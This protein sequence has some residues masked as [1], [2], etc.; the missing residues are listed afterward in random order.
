MYGQCFYRYFWYKLLQ[1]NYE[2]HKYMICRALKYSCTIPILNE[3]PLAK[4]FHGNIFN[5]ATLCK[6][7]QRAVTKIICRLVI[8][9]YCNTSSQC[10]T[11]IYICHAILLLD[12]QKWYFQQSDNEYLF[13]WSS[14][15]NWNV[16]FVK[17]FTILLR[18]LDCYIYFTLYCGP[19]SVMSI[20]ILYFGLN[21]VRVQQKK[22]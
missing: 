22:M 2:P 11:H 21:D 7:L 15:K 9:P 12:F 13:I 10:D 18:F 8:L 20:L 17:R 19:R 16:N 5:C 1:N 4:K 14:I 6:G 3:V